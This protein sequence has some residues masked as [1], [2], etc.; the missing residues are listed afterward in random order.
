MAIAKLEDVTIC[1][2]SSLTQTQMLSN[3]EA[4]KFCHINSMEELNKL[5]SYLNDDA[6]FT[7]F[8]TQLSRIGEKSIKTSIK[9]IMQSFLPNATQSLCNIHGSGAKFGLIKSNIYRAIVDAVL[10]N[11]K[12]VTKL[13]ICEAIMLQLKHASRRSHGGGSI[14]RKVPTEE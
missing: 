5:N 4:F 11:N 10:L 6:N 8:K 7:S 14:V 2:C 3:D 13:E 9:N 1:G 12:E